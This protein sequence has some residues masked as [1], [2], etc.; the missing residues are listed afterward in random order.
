MSLYEKKYEYQEIHVN[1]LEDI[2]E[3][4]ADYNSFYNLP[5]PGISAADDPTVYLQTFFRGQSDASWEIQASIER[6]KR[7]EY[8]ILADF[9][10]QHDMSLFDVIAYIQHYQT[11]TRFID[12]TT[13]K[14]VALYFTCSENMDRDGALFMW[15]YEPHKTEWYTTCVLTEL[16]RLKNDS[17]MSVQELSEMI[18]RKYPKIND[19]FKETIELNTAIVS[20]LDHGFM[21]VPPETAKENNLRLKRQSGCFYVCGVKF[22]HP[23]DGV[24]RI[25]SHAGYNKFYPH[26]VQIPE[27]LRNGNAL[28]KIVI[29][30]ELK[31]EILEYLEKKGITKEYLLPD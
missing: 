27:G 3:I 11:G 25:S 10:L 21:A 8:E 18:L 20:F 5:R 31:E 9:E 23:L 15:G 28:V 29:C 7:Q 30:K 26:S 2:N 24:A 16:V 17:K 6:E 4:I 13:D 12:F 1:T 14:N 22:E 19:T